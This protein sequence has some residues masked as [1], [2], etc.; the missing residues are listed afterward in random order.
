MAQAPLNLRKLKTI[1][2]G[3]NNAGVS[4]GQSQANEAGAKATPAPVQT[5][6]QAGS[7]A[8]A[9][10]PDSGAVSGDA[11][12]SAP[13]SNLMKLRLGGRTPSRSSVPVSPAQATPSPAPT[14]PPSLAAG[15]SAGS[16]AGLLEIASD[17]SAGSVTL[18]ETISYPDEIPAQ[19]PERKLP[20]ELDETMK[21][22]VQALD[23]MYLPSV[24]HDPEI[25]GQ[26]IRRI[27]SELQEQPQYLK[28]IQDDDVATMIRGMR[29]S[30]GMA[31]MRKLEAKTKRSGGGGKKKTSGLAN[32]EMLGDLKA[33]AG[34]MGMDF[35]E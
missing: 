2:H 19:A 30:M 25:C 32:D 22:F 27:M 15:S 35:D 31:R 34:A 3:G 23:S 13:S 28:L 24:I 5:P 9:A 1:Q 11:G 4:S 14:K 17:E 20:P 7:Q 21:G 18:A 10:G 29:D 12:S 26:M 33:L 6:V 8:P 16:S